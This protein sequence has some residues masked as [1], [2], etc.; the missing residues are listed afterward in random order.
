MVEGRMINGAYLYAKELRRLRQEIVKERRRLTRGVL[1]M[2]YNAPAHTSQVVMAAATKRRFEVPPHP[3][4]SPDLA[5]SDCYL[6]LNLKNN[7]HG[8]NFGNNEDIICC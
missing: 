7:L 3:P 8:R 5:P 4:Y 2:Q 1:L 6:F